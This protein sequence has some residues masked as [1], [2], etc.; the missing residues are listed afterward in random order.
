MNGLARSARGCVGFVEVWAWDTVLSGNVSE[1]TMPQA[2]KSTNPTQL[3]ALRATPRNHQ[4]LTQDNTPGLIQTPLQEQVT[5]TSEGEQRISEDDQPTSE[6]L[7]SPKQTAAETWY[8]QPRKKRNIRQTDKRC[9]RP[10]SP[11]LH[12]IQADTSPTVVE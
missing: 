12:P 3:C 2:Q 4:H 1:R 7:Q 5:K 9:P 6:G 8:S 10:R 11:C